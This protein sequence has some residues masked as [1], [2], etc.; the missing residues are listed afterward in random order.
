MCAAVILLALVENLEKEN[1]WE[2]GFYSHQKRN[3]VEAYL[4]GPNCHSATPLPIGLLGTSSHCSPS[5]TLRR[6]RG[7]QS[8]CWGLLCSRSE[9]ELAKLM[10]SYDKPLWCTLVRGCHTEDGQPNATLL[11]VRGWHGTENGCLSILSANRTALVALSSP[12]PR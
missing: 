10:N 2:F 6:G 3:F 9:T 11:R 5:V 8:G 7:E 12:S 4:T 1:Q